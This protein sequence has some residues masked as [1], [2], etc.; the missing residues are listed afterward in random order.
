MNKLDIYY[1]RWSVSQN[2]LDPGKGQVHS[3]VY[4]VLL[5]STNDQLIWNIDLALKNSR[6]QEKFIELGNMLQQFF[7][8]FS[9][10]RTNSDGT[11]RYGKKINL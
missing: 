5:D 9:I 3:W 1:F 8:D 11:Y 2:L 6:N 10:S 7:E 4:L